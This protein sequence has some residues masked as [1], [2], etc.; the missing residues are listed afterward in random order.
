M[1]AVKWLFLASRA[2]LPL[3]TQSGMSEDGGRETVSALKVCT[4]G[5][6]LYIVQYLLLTAL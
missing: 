2:P 6:L 1:A 4:A 5:D 3:T